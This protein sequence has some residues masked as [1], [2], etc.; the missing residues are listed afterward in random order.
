[1]QE[2]KP[3]LVDVPVRVNVWIREECQKKQFEVLK[4]ARPSVMFLISDGGRSDREWEAIRNNREM[5]DTQIDWDC[6]VYKVYEDKNNGLYTMAKKAAELIWSTVDRCV[7]LED[8][9]VPSVCYFRYCAELLEKYKDDAR[10]YAIAGMNHLGVWEKPKSD[11]FFSE[12]CSIWGIA[13][14]KRSYDERKNCFE[15]AGDEYVMDLLKKR[16]KHDPF[17]KDQIVGYSQNERYMGH[18][19]GGEFYNQFT[20]YAQNKLFIVPKY[21]M[22]SNIG[23]TEN[24]AHATEYKLLPKAIKGIFNMKTYELEFPLKHPRYVINDVDYV[25]AERRIMARNH[26]IIAFKRRIESILLSLRYKGMGEIFKRI[27][28]R[29]K[30]KK[31]GES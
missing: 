15:Y 1:M 14:W 16:T 11:Y 29:K 27:A 25:A 13:M 7:F 8:D 6:K 5:F 31:T 28:R 19:A 21:N 3:F 22:I 9:Y 2:I 18:V 24:S 12:S 20:V 4:Q 17:F 23:C 30:K 26:P 10:I